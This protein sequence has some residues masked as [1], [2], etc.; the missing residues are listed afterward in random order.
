LRCVWCAGGLAGVAGGDSGVVEDGGDCAGRAG[1]DGG[2]DA[3]LVVFGVIDGLDV[4]GLVEGGL[5]AVGVQ[6]DGAGEQGQVVKQA[7][8]GG[9]FGVAGEGGD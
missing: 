8:V 7:E 5:D 6:V 3:D 2:I 9:G 4:E 1:G